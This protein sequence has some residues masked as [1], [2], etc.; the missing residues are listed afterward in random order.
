MEEFYSNPF[1]DDPEVNE[2]CYASVQPSTSEPSLHGVEAHTEENMMSVSSALRY[3]AQLSEALRTNSTLKNT[4]EAHI[5][6]QRKEINRLGMENNELLKK[7][8]NLESQTRSLQL[9]KE[10]SAMAYKREAEKNA[11]LEERIALLETEL[12]ALTRRAQEMNAAYSTTSSRGLNTSQ[13]SVAY[14]RAQVNEQRA[15]SQA[16]TTTPP[17]REGG[18]RGSDAT[19]FSAEPVDHPFAN[20]G[21]TVPWEP[22]PRTARELRDNMSER[23][24]CYPAE[25]EKESKSERIK[26][27]ERRLL[28]ECQRRDALE[29]DLQRLERVKIRTGTERAKKI[30]LERNLEAAQHVISDVRMELRALSALER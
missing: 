29:L 24:S 5:E 6:T 12:N 23:L 11:V 15:P 20:H 8:T 13:A 21:K 7:I 4:Y 17:M 28:C 16:T 25:R 30:S 3:H 26:E 9:E 27:L 18:W 1:A 22:R 19:R 10:C 2:L 14:G